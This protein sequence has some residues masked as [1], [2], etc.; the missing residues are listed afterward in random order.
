MDLGILTS[1]PVIPML[2]TI[3]AIVVFFWIY[4][5]NRADREY[6]DNNLVVNCDKCNTKMVFKK[7]H[8]KCPNCGNKKKV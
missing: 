2:V 8:W 6:I 4:N 1:T 3:I 5:K 7:T